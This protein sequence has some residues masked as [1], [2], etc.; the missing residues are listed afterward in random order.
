MS[1]SRKKGAIHVDP[2][3]IRSWKR[4][5]TKEEKSAFLAYRSMI[6]SRSGDYVPAV[7]SRMA[8]S[9]K[10]GLEMFPS[11]FDFGK[12]SFYLTEPSV[13][14]GASKKEKKK[15]EFISGV[16]NA[17]VHSG[18]MDRLAGLLIGLAIGGKIP[19]WSGFEDGEACSAW[20]ETDGESD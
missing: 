5:M 11:H 4:M 7:A 10:T 8:A 14:S 12:R 19:H 18:M 13:L 15:K 3:D 2:D 9:Y 16:L 1:Y 17:Y 6:W 20:S